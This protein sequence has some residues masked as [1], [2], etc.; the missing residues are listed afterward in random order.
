ML[1]LSRS[2]EVLELGEEAFMKM[3]NLRFLM[4]FSEDGLDKTPKIRLPR[5]L[6]MLPDKLNYLHWD[7]YSHKHFAPQFVPQKLVGLV[8]RYNC[9]KQLGRKELMP[10]IFLFN[11]ES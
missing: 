4:F 5:G 11:F 6:K 2:N 7:R 10:V 9:I 3:T 8:L 1:N